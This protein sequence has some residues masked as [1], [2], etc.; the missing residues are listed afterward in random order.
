M[1]KEFTRS[2]TKNVMALALVAFGCFSLSAQMSFEI[3]SPESV[4]GNYYLGYAGFGGNAIP[5]V[6][7]ELMMVNSDGS[8][9]PTYACDPV[10]NDLTGRI[11]VIERGAGANT[12]DYSLRAYHAQQAGAVAA[13]VCNH[14][15]GA[16]TEEMRLFA[17]DSASA[18]TIPTF[19]V[20]ASECNAIRAVLASEAVSGR[21]FYANW[22]FDDVLFGDGPDG[23]DFS[24]P[25][26]DIGWT[27][28]GI[29]D[30]N[31][32]WKQEPT[33]TT[34]G[35]CGSFRILSP[36]TGN[37]AVMFDGDGFLSG[38]PDFPCGT[39]VGIA[40]SELISPVIDC[41]D[42]DAVAVRL[43]QFNVPIDL[44]EEEREVG[45][46]I[47]W[48]VDGGDIWTTPE[49]LATATVQN[50]SQ[51]I[52]RNAERYV[53]YIPEA[54]GAENFRF[55]LIYDRPRGFYSWTVDDIALIRPPQY[56]VSLES[57]F[58]TP[59]SYATPVNH[60]TTDTFGFS[61]TIRNKGTESD[62]PVE[63]NVKI[64]GTDGTV[65]MDQT[66][67]VDVIPTQTDSFFGTFDSYVAK[68]PVGTYTITYVAQF[69]GGVM[70]ELPD[71]NM[72]QYSFEITSDI[73]AKEYVDPTGFYIESRSA[74]YFW[75]NF[76]T[77]SPIA[78]SAD[79]TFVGAELAV[80][81]SDETWDTEAFQLYLMKW[82]DDND[83]YPQYTEE[84]NTS[85][86]TPLDRTDNFEIVAVT[87]VSSA[88]GAANNQLFDLNVADGVWLDANFQTLEEL[89][90]EAGATYALVAQFES[91]D[92][93]G[94]GQN[95]GFS[96]ANIAYDLPGLP[97]LL[98]NPTG[99]TDYFSSYNGS[100]PMVRL[101]VFNPKGNEN[102]QL[103]DDVVNVYPSLTNDIINVE[104]NF[105]EKTDAFYSVTDMSGRVY[106]YQSLGTVS[107]L[108]FTQN[109][110]EWA[111]GNYIVNVDTPQGR[112]TVKITVA[113]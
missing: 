108:S 43:W 46:A 75:G 90:L 84:L 94:D 30:P 13:L 3:T 31:A 12:C 66:V 6:A 69:A 76:Y 64:E 93:T 26:A 100:A 9:N 25:L 51:V 86:L 77:I 113:K 34:N 61:G 91:P 19:M 103:S 58:Y 106:A 40:G 20:G 42:F 5:E 50:T 33:S 49:Y 37:G 39:G 15:D 4:A 35:S 105:D 1:R 62:V 32:L 54:A 92:G 38:G 56:D 24:Q 80:G 21:V 53:R 71:D 2:F 72:I 99:G 10:T 110:S 109:V 95:I 73:F 65:H 17:G 8:D 112:K 82:K 23:W 88:A 96:N 78:S 68:L 14:A 47:S 36:T 74:N 85:T 89:E 16:A 67:T 59:L 28:V 27:T 104:M 22:G 7:A 45:T 87:E 81:V 44:D 63:L 11:A 52:H 98:Y 101:R 79:R 48:S 70:D 18:V 41:S 60:I 107:E 111:A 55:K 102:V 29:S 83:G 97:G 57:A